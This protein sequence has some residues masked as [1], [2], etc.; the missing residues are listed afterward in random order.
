MKDFIQ[1]MLE[2]RSIRRYTDAEVSDEVIRELLKAAMSAPS[3]MNQQPWHFTVIRNRETLNAITGL[4][5][6]SSM[7]KEASAAIVVSGDHSREVT[8]NYWVQDCSAATQNILLAA[9]SLGIGAVWLGVYPRKERV[10]AI[11]RLLN[12]PAHV[13]PLSIISLGMPAEKKEPVDRYQEDRIH[14]E[15]W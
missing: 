9:S 6:Y 14:W 15:K 8:E 7:L 12:M 13:S 1:T 5:P 2:R 11:K 10:E 3:A 4:H